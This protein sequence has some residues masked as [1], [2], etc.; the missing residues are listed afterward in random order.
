MKHLE[1]VLLALL[2]GFAGLFLFLSRNYN[3]TAAMV[4]RAIASV[5]LVLLALTVAGVLRRSGGGS[6]ESNGRELPV[7]GLQA[8]Y[9]LLIYLAGFFAATLI[10]LAL[11][12]IQLRYERKGVV[13]LHTALFT[14]VLAG[15]FLWL[16]EIQ[17][18][19]GILWELF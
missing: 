2:G 6:G 13:L 18:P 14:L 9:V 16:F 7:F 1:G 17:L 19:Q 4:P 5:A 3:E 10:Y 15:S 8:G 11:A 12:P